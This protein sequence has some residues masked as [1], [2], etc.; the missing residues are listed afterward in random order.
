MWTDGNQQDYID[1]SSFANEF[2]G[3]RLQSWRYFQPFVLR[4]MQSVFDQLE[5]FVTQAA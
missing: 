2:G 3:N 5:W 4:N 1:G